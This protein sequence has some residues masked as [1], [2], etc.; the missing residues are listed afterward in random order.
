MSEM[1]FGEVLKN[2]MLIDDVYDLYIK[3]PQAVS[4]A[5]AG[6]FL[7]VYTGD[8][9]MLLPRPLSICGIDVVRG[10]FR[11]VYRVMGAGTREIA[12]F[13]AGD[14][15]KILA[16]LGSHYRIE[17]EHT[18]FAVCGGGMGVP[19]MLA[20]VK[21]IRNQVPNAHISVFLGFRNYSQVMLLDDFDKFANELF[22]FTDDGTCGI[23][24]NIIY[25]LK[26]LENPEFD[27]IFGCGP[28][29]MLKALAKFASDKGM[30]C[31]VSI[32]ERMACSVGACLACVCKV[33]EGGGV[34]YKRVCSQGPVFDAK[35]LVWE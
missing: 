9:A 5:Q 16:P 27:T 35:E 34:A 24:G 30:P 26:S 18:K 10:V 31:H 13:K 29:G 21:K 14:E 1:V 32:E 23:K 6:Q 8:S 12:Q 15:L 25:G 11:V 7:S 33:H 28:H 4:K 20:L 22:V 17:P 3:A 2:E 19:P